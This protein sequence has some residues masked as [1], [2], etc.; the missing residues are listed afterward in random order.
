MED[1]PLDD[2]QAE[3]V[4]AFLGEIESK[5]GNAAVTRICRLAPSAA[6][7]NASSGTTCMPPSTGGYWR[8]IGG[9]STEL[10]GPLTEAEP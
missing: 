9:R 7:F 2:V 3:A 1:L 10:S 8:E 6:S 4:L 5:R